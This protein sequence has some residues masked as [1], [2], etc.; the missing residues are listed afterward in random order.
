MFSWL[1]QQAKDL[2]STSTTGQPIITL[3]GSGSSASK[4]KKVDEEGEVV[5]EEFVCVGRSSF[6]SGVEQP[7]VP[8]SYLP[9]S[10][11]P[12]SSA[13]HPP[14]PSGMYPHLPTPLAHPNYHHS[15]EPTSLDPI[16]EALKHVPFVLRNDLRPIPPTIYNA[17]QVNDINRRNQVD[18]T[19][20]EYDFELERSVV[21]EVY[22]Y[23]SNR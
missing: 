14:C 2:V 19:Q 15:T 4:K 1:S 23:Y 8:F 20:Y 9:Y 11:S 3:E 6:Y 12:S 10:P 16:H 7:S 13:G 17:F 5:E 22:Q 18:W 21:R